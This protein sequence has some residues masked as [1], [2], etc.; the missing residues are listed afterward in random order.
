MSDLVVA[1]VTMKF[2]GLV[3]LSSVNLTVE[4]GKIQALIGPNGSGKTTLFNVITGFYKPT[5]GS[6]RF[7]GTEIAGSPPHVICRIGIART[8]QNIK[9]FNEMTVL[10]NIMVG[11]HHRGSTEFFGTVF[12]LRSARQEE[13]A[14][15]ESAL[16]ILEFLKL[17]DARHQ[18]P[19]HLPYGQQRLVELGRALASQPETLLLDEPTAGMNDQEIVVLMDYIDRIHEQGCTIFLVEHHMKLVMQVSHHITVLNFGE[20][21][22]EGTPAEIQ[23]NQKVVE[24][25]LG[26]G[27]GY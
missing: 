26:T 6:V 13:R 2:G 19:K 24:A 12:N 22:A 16:E 25:Y 9:L 17:V 14:T 1:G 21:I 23:E 3:A 11:S 5:A 10:E 20:K 7:C 18:L 15:E 27:A 4:K 8:F